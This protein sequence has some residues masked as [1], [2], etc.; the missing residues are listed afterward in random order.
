[1]K[2]YI[3]S[4]LSLAGLLAD[5]TADGLP[6][7]LWRAFVTI[8][9]GV[10]VWFVKKGIEDEKK[11]N[12]LRDKKITRCDEKYET[13]V[14]LTASHE[15]MYQ[16]WLEELANN[17]HPIE[18]TRKTDKIHRLISQIAEAKKE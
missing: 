17:P 15:V 6:I 8:L 10:I 16:L 4:T 11:A 2:Y 18:G 9:I 1:M 5:N 3:F 12:E 7:W 13:L 14:K